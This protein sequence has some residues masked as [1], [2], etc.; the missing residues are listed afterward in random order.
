MGKEEVGDPDSVSTISVVV[1]SNGSSTCSAM[2]GSSCVA[3]FSSTHEGGKCA[4]KD[5]K[6]ELQ[7]T[8]FSTH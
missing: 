1:S 6:T 5:M 3:L 7:K 2:L 4:L 8:P